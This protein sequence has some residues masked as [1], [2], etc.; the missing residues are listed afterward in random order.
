MNYMIT[1]KPIKEQVEDYLGMPKGESKEQEYLLLITRYGKE[2]VSN[3]VE[4]LTTDNN[5]VDFAIPDGYQVRENGIFREVTK[6]N[7]NGEQ[8]TKE[9]RVC[10]TVYGIDKLYTDINGTDERVQITYINKGRKCSILRKQYDVSTKK[11]IIELSRLGILVN[12]TNANE[13]LKYIEEVI[14][15]NIDKIDCETIT[16]KMGWQTTGHFVP[17]GKGIRFYNDKDNS[18]GAKGYTTKGSLEEWINKYDEIKKNYIRRAHV[19]G[20]ICS[21][22][23][24]PTQ[25]RAF[26]MYL[27]CVSGYGKTAIMYFGASVWGKPSEIVRNFNSTNVGIESYAEESNDLSLFINEKQVT[28]RGENAQEQIEQLVYMLNEGKGRTRANKDTTL[29]ATKEWLCTYFMNGEQPLI[30]ENTQDGVSTRLIEIEGK[31]F[32]SQE[33]A[34]AIYDFVNKHHGVL[35]EQVVSNLLHKRNLEET[36]EFIIEYKTKAYKELM[37]LYEDRKQPIIDYTA[38]LVAIDTL[39]TVK[40]LKPG[41]GIDIAFNDAFNNLGCELLKNQ[42]TLK[43]LDQVE[44]FYTTFKDI[45]VMNVNKFNGYHTTPGPVP[46]TIEREASGEVWGIHDEE[47]KNYYLIPKVFEKLCTDSKQSKGKMLKAFIERGYIKPGSDRNTVKKRFKGTNN[48]YLL[49]NI[50]D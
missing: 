25:Q 33:E 22:F 36:I 49:F 29:K 39:I 30:T 18:F 45:L 20:S 24:R 19:I 9:I 32:D 31:P 1:E 3:L 8:E 27:W 40:I 50:N 42:K 16:S 2:T 14:A 35:G 38:F 13:N 10:A 28:G 44:K 12:D 43:E 17:Y 23:L 11:N 37:E 5:H 15:N 7:K 47:E 21:P 4:Y 6:F 48:N 41:I 26:G 46:R 34:R